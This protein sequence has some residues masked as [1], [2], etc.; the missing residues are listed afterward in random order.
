[1]MAPDHKPKRGLK[2]SQDSKPPRP[3][4]DRVGPSSDDPHEVVFFKRFR[5]DD[6]DELVPGQEF[7][8]GCPSAVKV[9]LQNIIISVAAAP[10][11]R[12]AGG[13]YWE[14]MSGEMSGWF[15]ARADGPGRNHF[16]LFCFLDYE[17][18]GETKPNLV[19]VTGIKK[20]FKTA[21]S[22]SDYAKVKA[23]GTEYLSRNPR[24]T[25]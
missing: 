22:K 20:K 3:N 1:M 16:R 9:K 18:I 14:A 4:A 6:P 10:P 19:I 2:K 23:L 24:S 21:L 15:E 17:A 12:F 25:A 7:L 8:N 11:K 13:G 5:S